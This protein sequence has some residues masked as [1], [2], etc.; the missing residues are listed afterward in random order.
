MYAMI[1][2]IFFLNQNTYIELLLVNTEVTMRSVN[3]VGFN[4]AMCLFVSLILKKFRIN[5]RCFCKCM[6]DKEQ[7]T[8]NQETR[9]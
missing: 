3:N 6:S 1:V 7:R 5:L 9:L 4:N 8:G 2:F